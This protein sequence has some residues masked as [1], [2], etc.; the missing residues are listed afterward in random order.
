M[1]IEDK[2]IKFDRLFYGCIFEVDRMYYKHYGIYCGDGEIIH[3]VPIDDN[4]NKGKAII[5]K[6]HLNDFFKTKEEFENGKY[7]EPELPHQDVVKQAYSFLG[8]KNYNLAFMNCEHFAR[9]C[10]NGKSESYQVEQAFRTIT[11]LAITVFE[12]YDYYKDNKDNK[13]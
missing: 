13:I 11:T 2:T 3:Y 7:Y 1:G 9:Y 5:K 8:S 6:T 10:A 4:I 12:I